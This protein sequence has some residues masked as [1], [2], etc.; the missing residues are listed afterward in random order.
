MCLH[1][2]FRPNTQIESLSI[3]LAKQ[4]ASIDKDEIVDLTL[5]SSIETLFKSL[6]CINGSFLQ[7]NDV[8]VCCSSKNHGLN[9]TDAE[10]AFGYIRKMENTSLKC[11]VSVKANMIKNPDNLIHKNTVHF[12]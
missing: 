3:N 12:S 6:A 11:V 10:A 8:H 2:I 7:E 4:C 5:M 9:I 1:F